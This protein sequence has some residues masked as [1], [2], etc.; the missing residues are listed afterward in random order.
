MCA[1]HSA[2]PIIPESNLSL[3]FI[4][5]NL[6]AALEII[7]VFRLPMDVYQDVTKILSPFSRPEIYVLLIS[8]LSSSYT[9]RKKDRP[10]CEPRALVKNMCAV[11]VV[12]PNISVSTI[13]TYR[14]VRSAGLHC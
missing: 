1:V 14:L 5:S 9:S 3:P 2:Q 11:L 10:F 4:A 8:A 6:Q 13:D 7:K 12:W